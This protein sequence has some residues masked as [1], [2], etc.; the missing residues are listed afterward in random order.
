[1]YKGHKVCV[2]I[3]ALNEEQAIDIVVRALVGLKLDKQAVIDHV[4]V[5]DNGSTDNTENA[6]AA[7][8]AQVVKQNTPGQALLV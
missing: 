8:G 2:V 3:P 6:A 4:V 5:C 7:A 1:M